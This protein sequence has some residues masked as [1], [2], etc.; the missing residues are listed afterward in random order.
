MEDSGRFPGAAGRMQLVQC[1][2]PLETKKKP[3]GQGRACQMQTDDVGFGGWDAKGVGLVRAGGKIIHVVVEEDACGLAHQEAAKGVVDGAG[4]GHHIA[5]LVKDVDVGG[6][7][8]RHLLELAHV[9]G[10]WVRV[11]QQHGVRQ[12][13][14]AVVGQHVLRQRVLIRHKGGIP[15]REH[16]E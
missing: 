15:L 5:L 2:C 8:A 11:V 9:L 6:A 3:G 4:D 16:T 1:A 14:Y 12:A 13:R 7:V 10:R